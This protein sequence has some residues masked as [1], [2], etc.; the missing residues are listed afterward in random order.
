M[1]HDQIEAMTMADRIVV[2]HDGI[3]EQVGTPLE[4]YDR[5]ANLFVASFLG[6]PAMNFVPGRLSSQSFVSESGVAIPLS[7]ATDA[8]PDGK[9]ICGFRPELVIPDRGSQ[10]KLL[11]NQTEPTGAETHVFGQFGGV[12]V[13]AVLRERVTYESGMEIGIS[14][15][16][17]NI[18]LFESSTGQRI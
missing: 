17:E 14:I 18:H 12:D 11:V 5:P 10:L 2:M 15:R 13:I 1:T 4:L 7:P 9:V 16:P 3:V 8:T 6:S